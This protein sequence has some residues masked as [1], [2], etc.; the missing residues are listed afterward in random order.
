MDRAKG[1]GAGERLGNINWKPVSFLPNTATSIWLA[2]MERYYPEGDRANANNVYGYVT[3]QTMVRVLKQCGNNLTREN[4]MK[5][6]GKHPGFST[7]MMLPGIKINTGP[8]DFFPIEQTQLMKFDGKAWRLVGDV[9][10][11]EVGH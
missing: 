1:I 7:E 5:A 8:D 2:F 6:G 10:D 3:A 9:I 11:G 4:I